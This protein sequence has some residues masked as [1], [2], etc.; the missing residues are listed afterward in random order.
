MKNFRNF[1]L[2]FE[3]A[4]VLL[5]RGIAAALVL[6]AT[7]GFGGGVSF[8]Q[9]LTPVWVELGQNGAAVARVIVSSAD[10]CPT[11]MIDGAARRMAVRQPTPPG[12]RPA[13]ELAIPA[14]VKRATV[15]GQRLALPTA[16]PTKIVAFGDTGCRIKVKAVQD[17]D[18][19]S[20]WP[21]KQI[22]S[23]AAAETPQ[24]MIHV[25]DYL[26][27]ESPCP[28]GSEA[29]CGGTPEGDNWAAWNADFFAPAAK[30]LAAAPWAFTRGNHEDCT[31]SW[32][33]WFYYLDPRPWSGMCDTY[34][35]PYMIKLGGFELVM[36]DSSAVNA[37][38]PD[39]DQITEYTGQLLSMHPQNAWL[40]DH[41]PFWGFTPTLGGLPP[42]ALSVPLEEAWKRANPTGYTMILSG[43]IHLFEFINL[44]AGRPD[45]LVIGDGGTSMEPPLKGTIGGVEIHGMTASMT[46]TEHQFGYTLFTKDG[47]GWKF[48]LKDGNG[49]AVVSCATPA[50]ACSAAK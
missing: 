42:V 10:Q 20:Q 2:K 35:P 13:C 9:A 34:S 22:A 14:G 15:N 3:A 46:D 30:L 6:V 7:L 47:A 18:D 28:A 31:R 43:H 29:L 50:G 1:K 26:Y 23:Q 5:I 37:T 21:F 24:L 17:C 16:N 27:R 38:V 11:V 41:H 48:V 49:R 44:G 32:R 33:G 12:F 25:G 8:G 40:V 4:A 39:E 36:L 45:Q 19:P